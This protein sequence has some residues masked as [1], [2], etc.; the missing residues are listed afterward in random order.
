[1]LSGLAALALPAAAMGHPDL[2]ATA[3][4][5][6][7]AATFT[8]TGVDPSGPVAFRYEVRRDATLIASGEFTQVAPGG[9][10][11]VPITPPATE[12]I[13]DYTAYLAW[14]GR[15]LRTPDRSLTC[16]APAA[17]VIPV[18]PVMPASPIA[19]GTPATP[20]TPKAG[21]SKPTPKAPPTC[22][23]LKQAGAGRGWYVALRIDY[24]RCHRPARSARGGTPAAVRP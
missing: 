23:T 2:G 22:R 19:S 1:M 11:T 14:E 24:D 15:S 17:P 12:S 4:I 6:C 3:T 21:S 16:G 9:T 13:N 10:V 8:T 18:M 5:D 7:A 20:A